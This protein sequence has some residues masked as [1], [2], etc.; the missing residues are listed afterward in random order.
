MKKTTVISAISENFVTFE[1]TYQCDEL[2]EK[3]K[4]I[5]IELSEKEQVG[6]VST[7]MNLGIETLA[8]EAAL[9]VREQT[10]IM[11][12]CVI[13]FEEQAVA[14]SESER[15][16]YFGIIEKCDKETMLDKGEKEDSFKKCYE[17][18]VDA[19]DIIL[20]GEMPEEAAETVQNS[21]KKVIYLK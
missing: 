7:A 15:D 8:A 18:L 4:A 2:F 20:V 16:R 5:L 21:G 17:Y 12:E 1:T 14:F 19:A 10:G 9:A 11:L 13:P 3:L 6:A